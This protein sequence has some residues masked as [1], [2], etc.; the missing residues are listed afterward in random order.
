MLLHNLRQGTV[1][2]VSTAHS[3]FLYIYSKFV[4]MTFLNSFLFIF[5][6]TYI[7]RCPVSAYVS[8]IFY[9]YFL[10][11]CEKIEL[12]K[13]LLKRQNDFYQLSFSISKIKKIIITEYSYFIKSCQ[14]VST[15]WLGFRLSNTYLVIVNARRGRTRFLLNEV[16]VLR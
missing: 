16:I 6:S 15:V 7:E 11:G 8:R 3:Q 4:E 5:C 10:S 14:D 12:C 1:I 9:Q 13:I 2:S